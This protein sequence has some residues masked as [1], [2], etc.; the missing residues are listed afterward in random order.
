M[1]L[2]RFPHSITV[3]TFSATKNTVG[4]LSLTTTGT[5]TALCRV[6]PVGENKKIYSAGDVLDVKYNIFMEVNAT[7]SALGEDSKIQWNGEPLNLVKINTRQK[8]LELLVK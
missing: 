4:I 1:A 2:V 7:I 8:G 6:E 5:I 3:Y